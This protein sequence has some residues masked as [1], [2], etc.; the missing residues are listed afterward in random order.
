VLVGQEAAELA[1]DGMRFFL[2]SGPYH[3]HWFRPAE[4][5][6]FARTLDV[7]GLGVKTFYYPTVKGEWRAQ[8]DTGIDWAFAS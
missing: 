8:F 3:S 1:D 4:T 6:A 7:L 5:R 2:S